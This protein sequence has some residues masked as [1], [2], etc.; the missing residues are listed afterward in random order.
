M[1]E[2]DKNMTPIDGV[3]EELPSAKPEGFVEEF[4]HDDEVHELVGSDGEDNI[5]PVDDMMEAFE[6][7]MH[8]G[9]DDEDNQ[10][11]SIVEDMSRANYA[12]HKGPVYAVDVHM[13]AGLVATGG[14]DHKIFLWSM[15]K[16]DET[17]LACWIAHTDSIVSLK[18]N[19]TGS[20]LISGGMDGTVCVWDVT[21]R[22]GKV[23]DTSSDVST[24]EPV[25]ILT[26][27]SEVI[28]VKFSPD[29]ETIMAGSEDGTVWLWYTPQAPE[30]GAPKL[31][32]DDF[33]QNVLAHHEGSV[34]VGEFSPDGKMIVTGSSDGNLIV[35]DPLSGVAKHTFSSQVDGRFPSGGIT[36]CAVHPS[37]QLIL[38]GSDEGGLAL[39]NSQTGKLISVHESHEDGVESISYSPTNPFVATAGIDGKVCIFDTSNMRRRHVLAHQE[40]V[41]KTAW[42]P[43]APLLVTASIDRSLRVWDARNGTLLKTLTAH[44]EGILDMAVSFPTHAPAGVQPAN[45]RGVAVTGGDDNMAFLFEI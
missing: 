37:S 10:D 20:L 16:L 9:S 34:H 18:F 21:G 14:E 32:P 42:H 29:Y 5:E 33:M 43:V 25:V 36:A 22:C 35:V 12:A 28:W 27:P 45:I 1:S 4:L 6:I 11:D 8:M 3:L 44:T 41:I 13:G 24:D 2:Q 40:P 19:E 30:K 7:E 38:V 31:N 39:V 15:Y 17:P 23:V 26:G